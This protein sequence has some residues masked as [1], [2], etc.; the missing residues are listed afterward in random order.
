MRIGG[1]CPSFFVMSYSNAIFIISYQLQHVIS[2]SF[3]FILYVMPY[4]PCPQ[5]FTI[6]LLI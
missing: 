2:I 4:L 6:S 3:P 5:L 1:V